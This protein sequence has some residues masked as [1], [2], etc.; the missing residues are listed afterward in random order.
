MI[1]IHTDHAANMD[2]WYTVD[3]QPTLFADVAVVCR[4]GSRRNTFQRI[5]VVALREGQRAED[6]AQAMMTQK[7][8]RGYVPA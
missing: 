7:M 4:W 3:V 6:V 1:L 5:R 2:R 8:R